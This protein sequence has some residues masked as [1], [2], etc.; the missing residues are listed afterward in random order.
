MPANR[1]GF[2]S[3]FVL[4]SSQVG[5]GTTN[6]RATVDVAGTVI[7]DFILSGDTTFNGPYAGFTPQEQNISFDTIV[8]IKTVGVG[9]FTQPY[10][11]ETGNLELVGQFNTVSEDIIVDEG[12]IFEITTTNITGI[13]TLGTQEVYAPDPSVVSVGTLESVSIQSHF[14]VPDGGISERVDNPIEGSVRFND[15]L[16]TLEF[17]NGVEWR[18]FTVT[19]ASGR[20]YYFGGSHPGLPSTSQIE[21]VNLSTFGNS[22]YFGDLSIDMGRNAGCS[23]NVRGISAGG[24]PSGGDTIEYFTLSSSGSGADFGNLLASQNRFDACSSSTRGVFMGGSPATNVIQYITITTTGNA[25]DFGDLTNVREFPGSCSS[26][27]RGICAGG[28]SPDVTTIIDVFTIA[29]TGDATDFGDLIQFNREG[30]A[31]SNSIR[32]VIAGGY[33]NPARH[34]VIQYITIATNGSAE[35]FG[36]LSIAKSGMSGTGNQTRAVY[37]GCTGGLPAN[38]TTI[39]S[40]LYATTGNSVDFGDFTYGGLN[41]NRSFGAASSDSHGGLGGF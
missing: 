26:P 41:G 21:F 6:P 30:S 8:G 19:G 10:E 17:Y 7:G 2:S 36:D 5:I 20:A 32:G 35:Y 11:T 24:T 37:F 27:V 40:I 22:Q 18:Q 28:N 13:T 31:A 3:D 34:N 15:D 25:L 14:S 12:K 39:D 9:T 33:G 4:T 38:T 23:S 1:I 16:N 29:S